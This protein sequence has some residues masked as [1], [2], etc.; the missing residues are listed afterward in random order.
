[1][2]VGYALRGWVQALWQSCLVSRV[3]PKEELP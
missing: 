3:D 2:V 1:M